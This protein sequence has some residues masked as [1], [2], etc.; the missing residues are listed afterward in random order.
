[1]CG[2]AGIFFKKQ[3]DVTLLNRFEQLV[4]EKQH[5]RGPDAFN[6]L[7]VAPGLFFFHNMLSIIDIGN[8]AQP[9]QDDKGAITYNGEVYNYRD[10]KYSNEIYVKKSDTE[11]LLKGLNVDY[12][13]FLKR[14]NSM[15]GFGYYNKTSRI[16]TMC[17]DRIGIKPVYFINTDEVF[18]FAS[19]V[20]PLV[21][22][23]EKKL[24]VTKLWQFYLNRAFK[25]PDTIFEDIR[26]LPSGS[27]LEF[28]TSSKVAGEIQ[29]WWERKPIQELYTNE[30]ETIEAI[31]T[32]LN[33][34]I[35]NRLVADVPVGLFLSGGVDSSLVAALTS[36]QT[37]SLNAF[38]VAFHDEKYDESAYAKRVCNQYNISYNEIKVDARDFLNSITDWITIQD[39]IVADPSALLLFKISEYASSKNYRA[40]LAGEGSDELFAGYNSYKYFNWSQ[41]I[42]NKIGRLTPFKKTILSTYKNNSKRYN[43]L[44]NCI[45]NPVFY[46]TAM[47]FEPHLLAQ[48]L[49]SFDKMNASQCFDLKQAMDLDIKD[50]IPNDVL[51]RSD[52]ST[53]G[54]AIELRVPFLA[55]QLVDFSAG[56]SK[57]LL[58]KNKTPKYLVKKLASKYLDNDLIYRK[59]V[60]FDLPIGKWLSNELKD[61]LEFTINNSVQKN[62]IDINVIKKCFQLHTEKNIDYSSKLWAFLC[63]ELS[64][65]YLSEI[66]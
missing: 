51:T 3:I 54:T 25:A 31:E 52:R 22:F 48:L 58:M 6:K 13:D 36:K 20:T 10:L 39:D 46:G 7:E 43:F 42:Y 16:L 41:N 57:D 49:P 18:A 61:L 45:E 9:M 2:I 15:F 37:N 56:I 34:S 65:K 23:S 26:E 28:D 47:I 29:K 1:M 60:G 17:R 32:L 24:N 59:K 66:E 30:E 19:T 35:R 11:V 21:I 55:H 38:T 14:T 50:R 5:Q 62:F 63:I 12:I 40:L 33:D 64:Y 8:A 27:F 53:S 4:K 44:Y